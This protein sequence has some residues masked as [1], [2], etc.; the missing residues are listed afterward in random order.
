VVVFEAF[1]VFKAPWMRAGSL[2]LQ[3]AEKP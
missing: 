2:R 3:G 1:L